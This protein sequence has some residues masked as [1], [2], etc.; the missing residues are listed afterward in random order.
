MKRI[1]VVGAGK[2][3]HMIADMLGKSGD[4]QL[5]VI[6]KSAEQLE[7]LRAVDAGRVPRPRRQRPERRGRGPARA[8]TRC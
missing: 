8:L 7:R 5:A 2:I 3:G 6:D 4:Y 1:A